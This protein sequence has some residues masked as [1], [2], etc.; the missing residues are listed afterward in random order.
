MATNLALFHIELGKDALDW[1]L[2]SWCELAPADPWANRKS[3][4]HDAYFSVLFTT[5]K[6]SMLRSA[7]STLF[8]ESGAVILYSN[9]RV[10]PM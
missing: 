3:S 4:S 9:S 8:R 2:L 10:A 7:R 5:T 1:P 6:A